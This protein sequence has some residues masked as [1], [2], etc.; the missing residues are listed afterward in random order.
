MAGPM[1]DGDYSDVGQL[2]AIALAQFGDAWHEDNVNYTWL[3]ANWSQ[4]R[5][6]PR[7]KHW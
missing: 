2:V 4:T 1:S 6:S 3:H 7:P 5:D